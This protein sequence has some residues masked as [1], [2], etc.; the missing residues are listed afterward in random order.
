MAV[1]INREAWLREAVE[2]LSQWDEYPEIPAVRVGVGFSSKGLRSKTIGECWY[3][4]ASADETTEIFIH[5]SL[6][7]PLDVLATLAH[8]L[9]HAGLGPGAGHGPKFKR[10]AHGIGLAGRMTATIPGPE[11]KVRVLDLIDELGPYPHAAFRPGGRAGS[12]APKQS[13]RMIR[14]RC[15]EDGYTLRTTAKWLD[16]AV[17]SCPI[18][19]TW[20]DVG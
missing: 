18:C 14:C 9:V 2:G 10:V 8:E 13:T 20:M 3:S 15:P 19:G 16:M 17:P 1:A 6:H 12:L 11:F 4:G 7:Q 5:P